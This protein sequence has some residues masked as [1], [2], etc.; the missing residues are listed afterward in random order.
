MSSP[1][2]AARAY[3]NLAR[4]TDPNAG[5]G[6]ALGGLGGVTGAKSNGPDFSAVLKEAVG[7]VMDAGKKSDTQ[8]H[9]LASGKANLIDVATAV[10]ET[11]VA[12]ET[13]VSV[14]DKVIQAYEEIMRMQI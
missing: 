1:I 3:A 7:S 11:E 8:S 6:A 5:A 14:R 2:A 12:I 13:M 10:A 9:A 4:I